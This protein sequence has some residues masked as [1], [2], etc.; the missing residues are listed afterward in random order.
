[1]DSIVAGM[2]NHDVQLALDTGDHLKVCGSD[3]TT[4]A[5]AAADAQMQIY[6][7]SIA[8]LE[9]PFYLAM[10][11]H[12]CFDNSALCN[13]G[14]PLLSVF[15]RYQGTDGGA[16]YFTFDRSTPSGPASFVFIADTAWDAT[17]SAWLDATLT[18][19]D[20]S[21]YTIIAKH[22]PSTNVTDFPTN[23]DEM[24]IINAHHYALLLDGHAHT[25]VHA[26]G[27]REIT[28]GLGGAPLD[29]PSRDAFGFGLAEQLPDGRLQ[30]TI[31]DAASDSPIDQFMVSGN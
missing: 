15:Q 12:E 17:E 8:A 9:A 21:A 26:D 29:H 3:S 4:I 5:T 7:A 23:A 1:M 20:A 18:R 16:P 30:V 31:Y 13:A 2:K 24:T 25:Y 11:N 14:D 6:S 28:L 22:V 19:T 10:G 27:G